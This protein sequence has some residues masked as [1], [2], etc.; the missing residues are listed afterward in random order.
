MCLL[1]AI[2]VA[3]ATLANGG[4]VARLVMSMALLIMAGLSLVWIRAESLAAPILSR[5]V[6]P[7]WW[8]GSKPSIIW[9]L[10]SCGA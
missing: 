9:R 7:R 2:A 4:R 10:G 5:P 6:P 1:A 3:A 8:H